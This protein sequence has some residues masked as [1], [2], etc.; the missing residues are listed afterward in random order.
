MRIARGGVSMSLV[1]WLLF[2]WCVMALCA[3]GV[4]AFVSLF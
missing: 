1:G 3:W 4:A 2:A